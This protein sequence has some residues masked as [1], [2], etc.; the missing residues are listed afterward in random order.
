MVERGGDGFEIGTDWGA[1]IGGRVDRDRHGVGMWGLNGLF[2]LVVRLG[3]N[4]V[5]CMSALN[6]YLR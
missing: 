1:G 5:G 4:D 2:F 3:G 6:V